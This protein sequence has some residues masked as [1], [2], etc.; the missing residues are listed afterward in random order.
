MSEG[1]RLPHGCGRRL[2]LD[3]DHVDVLILVSE[4]LHDVATKIAVADEHVPDSAATRP[5][6]SERIEQLIIRDEA[7][8]DQELPEVDSLEHGPVCMLRD[9]HN[10]SSSGSMPLIPNDLF[11]A[12]W[13]QHVKGK[14]RLRARVAG[15]LAIV[16]TRCRSG[17]QGLTGPK[18]VPKMRRA[19]AAQRNPR[20][21]R[22]RPAPAG[23]PFPLAGERW[24][25][26]EP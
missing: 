11:I 14:A 26:E 23:Y 10:A 1:M 5:M 6:I 24:C 15:L 13:G 21:P 12:P 20:P 18:P 16:R 8:L 17:V 19:C 9:T 25:A 7:A 2:L 3:V 22:V 4:S